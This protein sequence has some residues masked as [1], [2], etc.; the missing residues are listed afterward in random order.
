MKVILLVPILS[1]FRRGVLGTELLYFCGELDKRVR[2][3]IFALRWWTQIMD[4][5]RPNT[6]RWITNYGLCLLVIFYL[7]QLEKPILP[8][9]QRIYQLERAKIDE[10]GLLF[11]DDIRQLN[12]K[13]ENIQSIAE[14]I[15]GFFTYYDNFNYNKYA[16][17][18]E[19]GTVEQK[20]DFAPLDIINLFNC[21][22]VAG[23]MNRTFYNKLRK[24]LNIS[25]SL[26]F[27]L[28]N[29]CKKLKVNWGLAK[30]FYDSE[31]IM[32]ERGKPYRNFRRS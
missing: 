18:P 9:L 12:F 20:E 32:F 28:K 22:N 7:Q 30:L 23:N 14:L 11:I 13:T 26:N 5:T 16:I 31:N 2:P 29:E 24:A 3:L 1:K 6:G 25:N 8:S 21:D 17:C 27:D 15:T 4:V 10:H 19:R